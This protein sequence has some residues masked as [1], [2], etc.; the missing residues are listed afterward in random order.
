MPPHAAP[1]RAPWD[2]DL[3]G[4]QRVTLVQQLQQKE[5]EIRLKET[6][7]SLL[8]VLQKQGVR[9]ARIEKWMTRTLGPVFSAWHRAIIFERSHREA[10]AAAVSQQEATKALAAKEEQIVALNERVARVK[11]NAQSKLATLSA[12]NQQL[13]AA[14]EAKEKDLAAAEVRAKQLKQSAGVHGKRELE[15]RAQVA[16]VTELHRS[17][18]TE[19]TK[20]R[21]SAKEANRSNTLLEASVRMLAAQLSTAL[22]ALT[23]ADG[24]L[25]RAR[26][27]T[28]FVLWQPTWRH[29]SCSA[30]AD[31]EK[32]Q[33]LW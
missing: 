33:R 4:S 29:S 14:L 15:L 26:A 16:E 10:E 12:A 24:E 8:R 17:T 6:Q 23:T 18:V 28:P 19:L 20:A 9:E 32:R 30:L 13:A 25:S 3:G 11:T 2:L 31:F 22:R 27:R 1:G 5:E 7:I 21:N